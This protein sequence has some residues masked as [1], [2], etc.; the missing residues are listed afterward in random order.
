M[1]FYD[2]NESLVGAG[3]TR[4]FGHII[5]CVEADKADYSRMMA[6]QKRKIRIWNYKNRVAE[7]A[8]KCI[9][10]GIRAEYVG[11]ID[12]KKKMEELTGDYEKCM[13][14]LEYFKKLARNDKQA[15]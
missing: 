10:M 14:N 12:V 9:E 2:Y 7:R 13:K 8:K 4:S 5:H 11:N 3:C 15:V 1:T 6:E